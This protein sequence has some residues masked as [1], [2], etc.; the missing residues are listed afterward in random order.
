[1]KIINEIKEWQDIRKNLSANLKIGFVPTMGCLHNG[2]M[3]LVEKSTQQN[4]ITVLS[5]F[6]NPTQFNDPVDYEKYPRMYDEDI[7]LAEQFKVDYILMPN[8]QDMY[9]NGNYIY[10]FTEH[11]LA[12]I[13]EGACRPNHFNGMLT[14]VMKLLMLVLPNNAYFGEKDYQ[15]Y[16]L[17]EEMVKNYFLKT[18]IIL[19]PTVREVS[20]L[21]YSSRNKRLSFNDRKLAEKFSAVLYSYCEH[22]NI[23]EIKTKLSAL[24]IQIDY[25]DEYM[26]RLF[27]AVRI[28][29]IRLID[30]VKIGVKINVN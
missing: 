10:F 27:V 30:N 16:C 3:S 9:P 14:V 23:N 26:D 2:H 25:V 21:P 22:L 29:S 5:I 19:C 24:G 4:D 6:V 13:F 18:N 12:K 8:S 11:P 7:K 15:Q 28:G 20:G 17:I 1:M